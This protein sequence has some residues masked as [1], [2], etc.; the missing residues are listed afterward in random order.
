MKRGQEKEIEHLFD[1]N[2]DC[3]ESILSQLDVLSLCRAASSCHHLRKI[4]TSLPVLSDPAN[5][6]IDAKS[7]A[8]D[9]TF[10]PYFTHHILPRIHLTV[11]DSVRSLAV[12]QPCKI[13]LETQFLP[14]QQWHLL[15]TIKLHNVSIDRDHIVDAI[16]IVPKVLLYKC[17]IYIHEM[18]FP[19][20]ARIHTLAAYDC[21]APTRVRVSALPEMDLNMKCFEIVATSL[22]RIQRLRLRKCQRDEWTLQIQTNLTIDTVIDSLKCQ[23]LYILQESGIIGTMELNDCPRLQNLH[24]HACTLRVCADIGFRLREL[25]LYRSWTHFGSLSQAFPCLELLEI[26]KP[27]APDNTTQLTVTDM[28]HLRKLILNLPQTM[29]A[30]VRNNK[31]LQE[32]D[33]DW[34]THVTLHQNPCLQ[35]ALVRMVYD[36]VE[37][38]E[39]NNIREYNL[40]LTS[41]FEQIRF[42]HSLI[43]IDR[44]IDIYYW[45]WNGVSQWDTSFRHGDWKMWLSSITIPC[46]NLQ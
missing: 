19:E 41:W 11:C 5:A 29:H 6:V 26:R 20:T 32:L 2:R 40:L 14:S 36:G 45:G 17:R 8:E 21:S 44:N 31:R 3:L 30:T 22:D 24:L 13:Y 35:S 43:M 10:S 42:R 15:E 27:D 12:F 46:V 33:V 34:N 7:F 16:S 4:A 38:D 39:I 28:P 23:T 1:L 25:C 18:I 37:A 9:V